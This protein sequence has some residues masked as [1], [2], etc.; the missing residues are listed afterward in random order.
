[1]SQQVKAPPSPTGQ[2]SAPLSPAA[3]ERPW[4][5]VC[6]DVHFPSEPHV[7][8]LSP[9]QAQL[10]ELERPKT[11]WNI[12]WPWKTLNAPLNMREQSHYDE[13][14]RCYRAGA[15]SALS[16]QPPTSEEPK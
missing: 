12:L 16:P 10:K 11:L 15:L 4:C 6:R 7:G 9:A 5:Q 8:S 13:A 1:M 14:L 3:Q 2:P